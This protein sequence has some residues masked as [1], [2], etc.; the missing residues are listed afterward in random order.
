MI[1]T[2]VP[3]PYDAAVGDFNRDGKLDLVVSTT[4]FNGSF[5]TPPAIFLGSGTGTFGGGKSL[6]TVCEGA[7]P[8]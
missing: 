6:P 8:N 4:N 1:S 2:D 5:K 7:C 3:N